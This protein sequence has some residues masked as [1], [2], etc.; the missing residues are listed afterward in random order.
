MKRRTE[1]LLWMMETRGLL[2]ENI[3]IDLYVYNILC[4][5]P[6]KA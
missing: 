4:M 2:V 1:P 5:L 3:R 6:S